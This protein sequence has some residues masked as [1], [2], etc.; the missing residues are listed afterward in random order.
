MSELRF[1]NS[2]YVKNVHLC[3]YVFLIQELRVY[4]IC[5]VSFPLWVSGLSGLKL[6]LN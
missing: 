1:S 5:E 6:C 4:F 2:E 3:R